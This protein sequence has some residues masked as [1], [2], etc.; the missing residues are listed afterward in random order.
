MTYI[1]ERSLVAGFSV[2]CREA[3]INAWRLRKLASN[4][5]EVVL[6]VPLY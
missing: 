4:L 2:A 6:T 5:A 3:R 1:L